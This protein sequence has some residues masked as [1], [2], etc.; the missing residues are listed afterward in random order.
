MVY[1]DV[2][3]INIQL[4]AVPMKLAKLKF[5]YGNSKLRKLSVRE[6]VKVAAFDLPAGWSCPAADICFSKADKT[7]G[8]IT[9]GENCMFRCYAAS[10]EALYSRTRELRWHNF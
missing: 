8:K 2:N 10:T 7:T 6:S 9:D 5:S 3:L 1:N 4:E